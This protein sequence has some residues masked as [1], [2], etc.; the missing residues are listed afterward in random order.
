VATITIDGT[1]HE[2]EADF[3]IGEARIVKRYTNLNLAELDG[4]DPSNPDFIAAIIHIV[5]RREDPSAR[6]EEIEARVDAVKLAA[7]DMRD[8]EEVQLSPPD[9]SKPSEMP[10]SG[11]ETGE[12]SNGL[13]APSPEIESQETTGHLP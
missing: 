10:D 8:D 11:G 2:F 9:Q 4:D 12:P 1:D 7:I 13:P 3:D 5:F 6:F